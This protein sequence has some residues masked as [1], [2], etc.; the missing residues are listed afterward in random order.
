M[1]WILVLFMRSIVFVGRKTKESYRI[2]GWRFW[3]IS[4]QCI[5]VH[6]LD[7]LAKQAAENI[8][9][10]TCP[11]PPGSTT[12]VKLIILLRCV[13]YL[14]AGWSSRWVF[15][16]EED[17]FNINMNMVDKIHKSTATFSYSNNRY[18]A[19]DS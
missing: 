4:F 1:S 14:I 3:I 2:K 13:I 5:C 17:S 7:C 19:G 12:C 6:P 11:N 9:L 8:T 16:I 18:I 10:G 15:G